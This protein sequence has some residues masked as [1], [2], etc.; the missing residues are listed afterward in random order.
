MNRLGAPE[1][2]EAF[3]TRPRIDW[4]HVGIAA[5]GSAILLENP[6]MKTCPRIVA[7]CVVLLLAGC[8]S[9]S[10]SNSGYQDDRGWNRGVSS[11]YVGELSE[12]DVLGVDTSNITE[13]QIAAALKSSKPVELAPGARVMVVQSGADMP[14]EDMLEPLRARYRVGMFSGVPERKAPGAPADTEPR[15]S[16]SKGLRLAAAKGGYTHIVCYWGVLEATQRNLATKGV[17]W[18][19]I[20][21]SFVPDETQEMRIRLRLAVVDVRTGSWTMIAPTPVADKSLSARLNRESSDQDQVALLKKA[22]Y[23]AAVEELGRKFE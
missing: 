6:H 17:S 5:I 12:L 10:I 15:D 18:V 21:G 1:A 4:Q 11:S 19:P 14:D 23:R 3:S 2:A 8:A 20:A 13:E 22:G 9:R 7:V 16:Y